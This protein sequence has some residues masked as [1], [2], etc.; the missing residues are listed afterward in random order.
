MICLVDGGPETLGAA[1]IVKMMSF[2]A[3]T[4]IPRIADRQ[5]WLHL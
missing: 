1:Y 4:E 5:T 2:S 3:N